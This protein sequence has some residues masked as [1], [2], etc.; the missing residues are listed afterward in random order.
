MDQKVLKNLVYKSM[1][2]FYDEVIPYFNDIE[3]F[4]KFVIKNDGVKYIIEVAYDYSRDVIREVPF[5]FWDEMLKL[6]PNETLKIIA[7]LYFIDVEYND[8]NEFFYVFDKYTDLAGFFKDEDEDIVLSI[9]NN[10]PIENSTINLFI[11]YL[12]Y[13]EIINNLS[14]ENKM[15]LGDYI[16]NKVGDE[17]IFLDEFQTVAFQDISFKQK[18]QDTF[19]LTEKN[20]MDVIEDTDLLKIIVQKYCPELIDKIYHIAFIA[21]KNILYDDNFEFILDALNNIFV[22]DIFEE[23]G[24]LYLKIRNFRGLL[25]TNGSANYTLV[26][27]RDLVSYYKR[28]F[29]G[30]YIED[31]VDLDQKI[32][33]EIND[34]FENHLN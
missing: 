16:L 24:D 3:S 6:K 19:I 31:N 33:D 4:L 8:N 15:V 1:V 2:G 11:E 34:I 13:E 22:G 7:N 26:K 21:A 28:H 17:E 29:G 18:N 5:E 23:G 14:F 10:E 12:D 32:L 30:E 9:I 20:I 25:S 27:T